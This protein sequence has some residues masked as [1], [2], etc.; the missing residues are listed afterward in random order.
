MY[1]YMHVYKIMYYTG[2]F[3]SIHMYTVYNYCILSVHTQRIP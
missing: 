3:Y 2:P 1:M